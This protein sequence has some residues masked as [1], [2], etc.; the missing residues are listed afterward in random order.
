MLKGSEDLP[1]YLFLR[2]SDCRK[3]QESNQPSPSSPRHPAQFKFKV[4]N[5]F[6]PIK[7]TFDRVKNHK[8][9]SLYSMFY[10]R[11]V[12]PPI[13]KIDENSFGCILF[14]G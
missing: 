4:Y 9:W 7:D 11:D 13:N 2:I 14:T 6:M 1:R 8:W 5:T 3:F 12:F 10:P